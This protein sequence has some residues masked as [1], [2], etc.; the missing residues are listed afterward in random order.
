MTFPRQYARSR[1]LTL[2][3][4]R[5]FSITPDGASVLFLRSTG[6]DDAVLR[7]WAIDAES[8]Q[9]RLLADPGTLGA[10][11]ADLPAA[12]RAR[13][14][15]A[16]ESADGIVS[17][18]M[19]PTGDLV[20]FALA[21]ELF[22][23]D[24][25]GGSARHIDT[26]GAV[27]DPRLNADGSLVAYVSDRALRVVGSGSGSAESTTADR[28]IAG[29]DDTL[30]SWGRADFVAAEEMGR[31]R[32]FWWSDVANVL[33][34][35]R[36]DDAPVEQWWIA[37]PANPGQT[38]NEIRY[39]A[40]GTDNP[41]VRL[42]AIDLE[43]DDQRREIDWSNG[44]EYLADVVWSAGR[45]PLIVRQSRDQREVDLVE[46]DLTDL[47]MSVR[48]TI[49]EA[50]WVE[51]MPG[52]P[53]WFGDNSLLTIEDRIDIDRRVICI[54]GQVLNV[55]PPSGAPALHIKSFV[56]THDGQ[57]LVTAW[58]DPTE[59]HVLSID[60]VSSETE[61]L[62]EVPGVHAAVAGGGRVV[63]ISAEAERP[64]STATIASLDALADDDMARTVI[65][66][67]ADDPVIACQPLF[68]EL[69]EAS[70]SSVLFLPADHDGTE[71][72]PVLLD[73]YGG[74]H[75]QRVLKAHNSHL[76]SQWFAD[77]GFAVLVIDG[78]G[79]PGRGPAFER[80]VWGDLAQPVLDDQIA[81]LDAAA[82]RFA[83]LDLERVGIRGWSF[84]GYL[85][86]LGVMRRPDRI[87][88]AIAGAPVTTWH[89]Y[90][91]HYTERYLG[92]PDDY[93]AHY[94]AT[95]LLL[96]AEKLDR[97]LLLIHGLADDNVVAAH[98]LRFS[99][100]LLAA[101]RSHNVLPLSG[102]T[103]MTPQ[104]VVAENLLHLQ[105][106]FLAASLKSL[107]SP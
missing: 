8:G 23:V 78:R 47:S 7:L 34:A 91:T 58:T 92:H 94:N 57:L 37:D 85:S 35:T 107:E 80:A 50:T 1:R 106:D 87:H 20:A 95:D 2:G 53:S 52:S 56:G 62:T 70:L 79:T 67:F 33:L 6:A 104:E 11:D 66:S 89:L 102:V 16:R 28:Q 51:L 4:P 81:G 15:R 22:V 90:D 14:E 3:Q 65:E 18:S 99:S 59:V 73:P 64:G 46:L 32:G 77:Q 38:P 101:G 96:D 40:A 103:H 9:E 68:L 36:V 29:E 97:P 49:E 82:E 54:D 19:A 61:S 105:R 17:Y 88:A 71:P 63:M 42:F 69:G 12:E 39:P 98:T 5:T 48:Q 76:V 44:R 31:S 27:F 24:I 100:A 21:G 30:V 93:P 72:L 84:G 75:A 55:A 26:G 25:A 86:A 60:P 13:R 10:D 83:F 41:D 43:A 74:P 45:N